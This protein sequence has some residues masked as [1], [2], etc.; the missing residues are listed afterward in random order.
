MTFS[1]WPIATPTQRI[2]FKFF[3]G[4]A[5]QNVTGLE[6]NQNQRRRRIMQEDVIERKD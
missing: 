4:D 5:A 3:P 6:T 2:D 1:F